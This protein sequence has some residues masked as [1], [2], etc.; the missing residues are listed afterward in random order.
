MEYHKVITLCIAVK[1]L[2]FLSVQI[3]ENESVVASYDGG[4]SGAL[5]NTLSICDKQRK[6][7]SK[8]TS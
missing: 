5:P 1:N 7:S 8:Q 3:P 4:N 2:M 6:G